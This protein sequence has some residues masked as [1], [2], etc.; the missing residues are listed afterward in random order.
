MKKFI[1]AL[2][3]VMMLVS[4]IPATDLTTNAAESTWTLVTDLAALEVGDQVIIVA[5]GANNALS[6]T[7]NGNNRASTAITKSDNTATITDAVQVLELQAGVTAGTFAFYTGSGYLYAASGTKNY[8][9]TE[10]TLSANSSWNI[11]IADTGVATVKATGSN[12]RNWMRYNASNNPPIFSCYGSGQADICLYKLTVAEENACQHANTHEE[13]YVAPTCTATGWT[14]AVICDDCGEKQKA[15]TEIPMIPHNIVDGVCSACGAVAYVL[16]TDISKLHTGS[17]IVI[18]AT[19][20]DYTISTTQANN[21]RPQAAVT[22]SED[23]SNVSF[24]EDAQ[25]LTVEAGSEVGTYAFNTG[26]GYLYAAGG[27]GSNYL[28]TKAE[29]DALGSW[30]IEIDEAG[31]AT[32]KAADAA[33]TKNW[34]RYNE[35]SGI[36]SCYASGQKDVAIYILPV[37]EEPDAPCDH[38]GYETYEGEDYVA[39]TCTTTGLT[40]TVYCSNCDA[41]V[42]EQEELPISHEG[43]GTYVEGYVAPG[44]ETEGATGI[45]YCSNCKA[46]LSASEVIEATGHDYEDGACNNCGEEEPAGEPEDEITNTIESETYVFSSYA[47]GAQYAANE[48]H[49]LS[50]LVT[51]YTTESHFT[52]ELRLYS[53]S[54]HDGYAII[55]AGAPI[56]G[57]TVNAGN[58]VDTLVVYGSN[59]EGA[60]W[61]T[62]AEIAVTSTSYNDY[63]AAWVST[64]YSWLKLD[65]KGANQVRLKNM[66]LQFVT[67]AAGECTHELTETIPGTAATCTTPGKEDTLTCLCG[68]NVQEGAVIEALG[69]AYDDDCCTRCA[70]INPEAA[71]QAEAIDG[72][73]Q[74]G[75]VVIFYHP[76]DKKAMSTAFI[77]GGNGGRMG[78][79]SVTKANGMIPYSATHTAVMTV[80]QVGEY[81][82]FKMGNQ[83]LS[84]DAD[85]GDL[86]FAALPAEGET[87]YSLWD[88]TADSTYGVFIRSVNAAYTDKNTGVTSYN[89]TIEYY[90][91]KFYPYGYKESY[92]STYRI[93]I[94]LVNKITLAEDVDGLTYEGKLYLDLNG[95]KATNVVA[96]QLV[97]WDSSATATTAGTG[98]LTTECAVAVDNTVDGVRYIALK[99]DDGAYTFHVLQLQLSAVTLRTNKAG[100]YYKAEMA[101]DE[102]LAGQIDY[103]GVAVSIVGM[104]TADFANEA[105]TAATKISGAPEG[106][107]TSGSVTNIFRENLSA[108]KNAARGE[109]NIY[110]NSYIQLLDG[111]ILMGANESAKSM[112]DIMTYLDTNYATLEAA[113]QANALAF[114][115]TWADAMAGWELANLAAAIAPETEEAA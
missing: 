1:S 59:D 4:M 107:F 44:C 31:I 19:E 79:V 102:V 78:A 104:P 25:I 32:I 20:A 58:K 100:I 16:V 73:P 53:S 56:K 57:I 6:T 86:M 96:D 65:V 94:G 101:C 99:G 109:I 84:A 38:L 77:P 29:L 17:Q 66:T 49:V 93:Q 14:A 39:P 113:D 97:V 62:V 51:M 85:G 47:A 64:P 114:Y 91:D 54:S 2:L 82:R 24:G 110:A 35:T 75:D 15:S 98:S 36:F 27:T 34:I 74:A 23:G 8:L 60:T 9:R 80:E 61:T 83:Y 72:L 115:E 5:Q 90:Q 111:T 112:K 48:E 13:G 50:D 76:N 22:K 89:Q 103:H 7:Q 11:T 10:T 46:E 69:H 108:E 45:T 40:A 42:K 41:V 88:V 87:D 105:N 28:R 106:V 33:T 3:V 55:K 95:H 26:A 12:T 68:Q 18:V 30:N 70:L 52:T 67:A 37:A 63:S 92:L 81:F 71:K 43:Q 21:N